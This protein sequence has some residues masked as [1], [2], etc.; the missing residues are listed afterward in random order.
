MP[1]VHRF[2]K[3]SN[4]DDLA[5]IRH[6]NFGGRVGGQRQDIASRGAASKV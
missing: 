1:K 3:M 4:P 2:A 6:R 5:T